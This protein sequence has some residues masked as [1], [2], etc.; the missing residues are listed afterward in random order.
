MEQAPFNLKDDL[1]S[2]CPINSLYHKVIDNYNIENSKFAISPKKFENFA[3]NSTNETSSLHSLKLN[4]SKKRENNGDYKTICRKLDFSDNSENNNTNSNYSFSDNENIEINEEYT[5]DSNADYSTCSFGEGKQKKRKNLC[6]NK[7]EKE[8]TFMKKKQSSGDLIFNSSHKSRFDEEYV[9]IKTICNGEMGTVYLCFRIKDKKKYVIKM[10]R[11]F[12]RKFDYEN[13]INFV[14]DTNR[15][16]SEP[17]SMYIQKYI[18]FWIEEDLHE[19]NNK[20]AVNKKM[21]IVTDYCINGNLKEY[22]SNIKTCNYTNNNINLQINYAFYWDIIFQMIVPINFL[23]KLGY[24]HFDIKLTNYLVMNNTQLLLND[25]C[26]SI[27]EEN[28]GKI[29]SDELE[30]DSIYISPELFYKDIGAITHKIDIFSLGL[31][32]LELLTDI[33]LPKNGPIWQEI[34]NHELPK[35]FLDK[36]P[37]FNNDNENRNKLIELINEMVQINSNLRPELETVLNDENKYPELYKRYQLLK[38]NNYKFSQNSIA[39]IIKKTISNDNLTII[40]K[41]TEKIGPD[42]LDEENSNEGI[43]NFFVK[44]SNSMKC[45]TQNSSSENFDIL[46]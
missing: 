30:G 41:E 3:K 13:M 31:S 1:C 27:K 19:K 22:V 29:S 15:H 43:K 11:Y 14:N 7:K 36:I 12:S 46:N 42:Y 45:I 20:S 25:F 44:R 5:E 2:Q 23:H 39:N 4:F 9:I 17:G 8:M 6:K 40:N 34:R 38:N 18:D 35:E 32:I 28:I 10:S 24:I 33:S 37:L 21:Y 16:A 26:L